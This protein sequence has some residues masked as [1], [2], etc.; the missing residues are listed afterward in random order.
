MDYTYNIRGWLKK[1]N[2]PDLS[3][4]DG[5]FF[6]MELLYNE[7]ITALDGTNQWNGNISGMKFKNS[8][9]GVQKGYG[10]TYDQLHRLTA[11][12]YGQGSSFTTNVD[13][14]NE[15]M[16][17]DRNGNILT[18]SRKGQTASGV[19]GNLDILTYSYTGMGNQVRAIGDAVTDVQ[20]RG[21][22][23][24]STDGNSN[25]EYYYDRN[26][27]M[28][29]DRNKRMK[30]VYN[31]LNLPARISD[32]VNTAN[33][34][35]YVYTSSGVK[36]KQR[37]SA[38]T[39]L[40]Y[41][42]SFVYELD[43]TANGIIVKYILTAEGRANYL[44]G[45]YTYEYFMKDHLGNTR[46][47]FDVPSGAAVITQQDDYYPFGMLHQ[48]QDA[49]T[50]DN[51]YLYN[52]KE[53]Q[54][55]LLGGI[56][57]DLYDY[58]AR[59]YDPQIGRWHV[60]DPLAEEYTSLSPYNYVSNNPLVFI[61]PNG[62]AMDNYDIY[63]DGKIKVE[64]TDDK[65]DTF[66]Y[67]DKNGNSHS[68]G[69]FEKNESGYIKLQS[70]YSHE[71]GDLKLGYTVKS[72]N[73][74]KSYVS[75]EALAS[76]FGALA[77]N[78][79]SDLTIISASNSDGTSPAP[80]K[81]HVQGTGLD[82]R[83]LRDDKS[84]NAVNIWNSDI[85]FSRQNQFNKSLDKFGWTKMLSEHTSRTIGPFRDHYYRDNTH[86]LWGTTDY[87]KPG[88]RHYHHLHVGGVYGGTIQFKPNLEEITKK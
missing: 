83:Y 50:S 74:D 23:Y 73:E 81:S 56:N 82:L 27:N 78:N 87:A 24:D 65:S 12:K 42:G 11:A 46:T 8:S 75:G 52:G 17:Y 67:H 58:G 4:S 60:P 20:G 49:T 57:L 72:G 14:Y 18:L 76:L 71:S 5:D 44:S 68:L 88:A 45:A 29:L 32:T 26:G 84:G 59:F 30:T 86:K 35:E 38:G 28:W 70:E 7:D 40:L 36:L 21:D 79:T 9:S 64:R 15:N 55:N 69:T 16:T 37:L 51:R 3:G 47:A 22:F 31:Y 25:K 1:I 19:F 63:E 13:R 48:P 6:G 2:E 61:D 85:D 34:I 10:Y 77:D 62:M 66:T 53:F 54:N 33:K 43:G 39:T 41:N 80:S